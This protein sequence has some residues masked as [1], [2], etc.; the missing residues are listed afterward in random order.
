MYGS[1][2]QESGNCSTSI[3]QGTV[4]NGPSTQIKGILTG[5]HG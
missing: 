5:Y 2:A 3:A 1:S 4:T